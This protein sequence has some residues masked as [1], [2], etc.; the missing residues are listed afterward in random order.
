M[1]AEGQNLLILGDVKRGARVSADGSITVFGKLNGSANAGH[2][3]KESSII[4]TNF[5]P[6]I[7]S[8]NGIFYTQEQLDFKEKDGTV[9]IYLNPNTDTLVMHAGGKI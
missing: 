8:V 9:I 5:D 6:E 7:V 2:K 1:Y 4:A 3:S